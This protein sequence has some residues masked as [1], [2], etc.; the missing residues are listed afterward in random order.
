M[1]AMRQRQA[2]LFAAALSLTVAAML[3]GYFRTSWSK[4]RLSA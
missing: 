2:A 1:R 4:L 3:P